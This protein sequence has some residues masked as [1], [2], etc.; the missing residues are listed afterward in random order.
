MPKVPKDVRWRLIAVLAS[1]L[2]ACTFVSSIYH[3]E[4]FGDSIYD[5]QV[6]PEPAQITVREDYFLGKKDTYAI[7]GSVTAVAFNPTE[8]RLLSVA[9]LR[10]DKF[11]DKYYV[12]DSATAT[13]SR[14]PWRLALIEESFDKAPYVKNG[15]IVLTTHQIC[16]VNQSE[17]IGCKLYWQLLYL[18]LEVIYGK[19]PNPKSFRMDSVPWSPENQDWSKAGVI[20]TTCKFFNAD[21][22]DLDVDNKCYDA[23]S[24]PT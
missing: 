14:P 4:P 1:V 5:K 23:G 21:D 3:K 11:I 9:A 13:A 12:D 22:D 10:V 19:V 16:E 17:R 2:F 7:T 6:V 18:R 8:K 24:K 15:M 20:Q